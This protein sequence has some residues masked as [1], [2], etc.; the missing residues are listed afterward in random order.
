MKPSRLPPLGALRA[1]HSVATLLS[2]KR[3][4]EQ[5]SVS[6]TAVSHQIRLLESMLECR[7]FERNAQGVKL[8][9]AGHLLYVG[10][11]SAFAALEASVKKIDQTRQPPRLTI[12]TTSNFLTNWLV[13]RLAEFKVR[14]PQIDL[15]LHTSV[16][17]IDLTQKTVDVAI[18]YREKAEEKLHSTLLY[19]DRFIVVASPTL[20]L[21]QPDDLA[22]ATLFHIDNRHVPAQLPDWRH[23]KQRYGPATL[24]IARGLHFSDETHA[25]QA[26]VA[27]QGVTIASKLLAEDLI[28]RGMLVAPFPTSLPGANYYLVTMEE[29]ASRPDVVALRAWLQEKMAARAL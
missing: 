29:T 25:L 17:S 2:F 12:T 8:T 27:G 20:A 28:Q 6:A 15:H 9:E 16:E 3:A 7:V 21:K 23:W 14:F 19:E 22:H 11:Q 18:R 10:T 4:A 5:L 24:N 26:A 13:P 1:F